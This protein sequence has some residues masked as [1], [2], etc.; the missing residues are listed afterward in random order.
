AGYAILGLILFRVLWG[1]FGT[2]FARFRNFSY[3]LSQGK[4][5]AIRTISG[6]AAR[7]VG[8]NP[9][10]SWAIYLLLTGIFLT[11]ISGFFVFGGEEGHGPAG[12][13]SS[14]LLG[15]LAKNIHNGLASLMVAII[16]IHVAGVLFESHQLKEKLILS[17]I[18]GR[19]QVPEGTADVSP[20]KGVAAVLVLLLLAFFL[21]AGIGLIPG[22]EA[23]ESQFTGQALPMS[24]TWQTE[25]GACHMAYHP[26]LLA[27]R[28]WQKLL[29]QQHQHFGE[30]LYLAGAT[31]ADLRNYATANSADHG[32]TEPARK[33]MGSM[34]ASETPLRITETRYWRRKHDEIAPEVWQQ[35]N[36]NGKGQCNAC[37]SDAEQGWFEDSRMKIPGP[38]DTPMPAS[39]ND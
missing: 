33:I 17:M 1:F 13:L 12:Y 4:E 18:T 24:A 10:G 9:A 35:G 7:H 15:W 31:L 38:N 36:V 30:D 22:K 6:Q 25:C 20:R 2:H 39:S 23:F 14:D 28:S 37:H 29:N 26:T 11:V 27:S 32:M 16:A 21:S 3:S 5:Y 34:D 19:K 8:H